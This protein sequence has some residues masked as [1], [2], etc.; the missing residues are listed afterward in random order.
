M[1][2]YVKDRRDLVWVEVHDDVV[3]N[4]EVIRKKATTISLITLRRSEGSYDCRKIG[5]ID[6]ILGDDSLETLHDF[7]ARI[8][9]MPVNNFPYTKR[10]WEDAIYLIV[11]AAD[12]IGKH[13]NSAFKRYMRSYCGHGITEDDLDEMEGALHTIANLQYPKD[14]DRHTQRRVEVEGD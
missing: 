7:V 13:N 2:V 9:M 12:V 14:F 10:L 1:G 6:H 8:N 11:S 3:I 5:G 4:G